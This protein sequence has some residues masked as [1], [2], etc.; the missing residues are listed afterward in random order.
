MIFYHKNPRLIDHVLDGKP[1]VMSAARYIRMLIGASATI[2][3]LLFAKLKLEGIDL[4]PLA[5]DLTADLIFQLS[6]ALYYFCWIFGLNSD[7]D[8]Q[9][10]IYVAAPNKKHTYIGGAITAILITSLF[11]VLYKF[12]RPEQFAYFLLAF[13]LINISTWIYLTKVVM[14]KE[15][16]KSK[17]IYEKAGDFSRLE[18]LRLVYEWYLVGSWQWVRFGVGGLVALATVLVAVYAKQGHKTFQI[19]AFS[20]SME[21]VVSLLLL[22]YVLVMETWIWRNR[23][24]MTAQLALIDQL[25][26]RYHFVAEAKSQSAA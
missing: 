3:G 4:H 10:L 14:R 13:L 20:L 12:N 1:K 25:R 15:Y 11:A 6:M 22:L 17:E 7:T 2:L 23:I 21:L 16:L 8:E 18:K 9:E 26:E 24:I 19:T 5:S